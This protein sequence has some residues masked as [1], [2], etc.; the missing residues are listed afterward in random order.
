VAH[1]LLI[2]EDDETE[3]AYAAR[4]DSVG[5]RLA[6]NEDFATIAADASDDI[7]SS[8]VGGDLG[9]TDGSGLSRFDGR[10]DF[11]FRG[12][13]YFAPCDN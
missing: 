1:I 12:G 11:C 13:W 9:F 10:C 7:G 2:Q 3:D 5:S 8:F 6:A 4:V